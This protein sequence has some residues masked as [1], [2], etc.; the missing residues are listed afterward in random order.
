MKPTLKQRAA[1]RR[2][3]QQLHRA[4]ADYLNAALPPDAWWTTFPLGGGGRIRGAL[5]KR[6]GVKVGTPD[7]LIIWRGR[8]YWIELK[9]GKNK[10]TPEQHECAAHL[11]RAG[12]IV[13]VLRSLQ[14]AEETLPML[15][16][17]PPLRAMV[18]A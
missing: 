10:P 9:A 8:S 13:V 6:A 1:L 5:L 11:W 15:Q 3:E 18:A 17:F 7:I 12:S 16:G 14:E 4:V 2:P